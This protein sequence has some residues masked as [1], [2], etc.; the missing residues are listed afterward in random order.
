M[1][2]PLSHN[3]RR[4]GYHPDSGGFGVR[5]LLAVA[6]VVWTPRGIHNRNWSNTNSINAYAD[7]VQ[8]VSVYK[9][10]VRFGDR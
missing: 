6:S 9:K 4:W 10:V 2:T 1:L 7:Q 3:G 5:P 8:P